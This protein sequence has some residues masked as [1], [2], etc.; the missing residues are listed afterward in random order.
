MTRRRSVRACGWLGF[1]WAALQFAAADAAWA[2]EFWLSGGERGVVLTAYHEMLEDRGGSFSPEEAAKTPALPPFVKIDQPQLNLGFSA[3]TFWL[4]TVLVNPTAKEI[5]SWLEISPTR[6]QTVSLHLL[7]QGR[8]ERLDAGTRQPF[9]LRAIKYRQSVFPVSVRPGEK[10]T[11]Y[12]RIAGETSISIETRIWS[13]AAFR[14]A[15]AQNALWNGVQMGILIAVLL[16]GL[17]LFHSF[18]IPAFLYL[19]LSMLAY[20]FNEIGMKG[21]S[22]ML[23][24]PN[25]TTWAT[26]SLLLFAL[27]AIVFHVLFVR[28]FLQ[29]RLILPHWDRVLGVMIFV[30]AVDVGWSQFVDYRSG[31]RIG[32]LLAPLALVACVAISALAFRRGVTAARFYIAA[33]SLMVGGAMIRS[34]ELHGLNLPVLLAEY[35]LPLS[36]IFA[37]AILMATMIDGVLQSQRQDAA[38][39]NERLTA[40]EQ[41]RRQLEHAVQLRTQEL[42]AALQ[43][44]GAANDAKTTLLAR[45]S[46]D[47]RAPLATIVGQARLLQRHVGADDTRYPVA[48][49]NSARHQLALIDELLE[50]AHS[51]QEGMA[52]VSRPGYLQVFLQEIAHEA[53][54][55][56]SQQNN[57]F[58]FQSA[59]HLPAVIVADLKRLRQVLLNLL[60]NA[61]KFTTDGKIVLSVRRD[62]AMPQQSGQV[63]L[64]FEVSDT[65]PG[66]AE[67]SRE[68]IFEPF[69]RGPEAAGKPGVGLG[70]SI[71]RL[72]VNTAGGQLQVISARG[73]GSQF[74][75]SV[76]FEL[77]AESEVLREPELISET[78]E[79]QANPDDS[80]GGPPAEGLIC[81]EVRVVQLRR[82]IEHGLVTEIEEWIESMLRDMPESA[83]FVRQLD[84]ALK[85]LD[86][87]LL[88]RLVAKP[89]APN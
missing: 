89:G 73:C 57:R 45:I 34:L 58:V 53:E 86:F 61:A 71:A 80:S 64:R 42:H 52:L 66:I 1:L 49:E 82:F 32:S 84:E 35:G 40:K 50:F 19:S 36:V 21:Y 74:H 20:F 3:S 63:W 41:Q 11:A 12:I 26:S 65:G 13:E 76:P 24:W 56:A 69:Q 5:T 27:L 87:N 62:N 60:S 10:V 8:W 59:E 72:I 14:A 39:Q 43:Q 48:I 23:L 54:F 2:E 70:L 16:C 31:A 7:K 6:L 81:P 22:F 85:R 88:A 18:R 38:S 47:L 33:T 75:F 17:I 79:G 37:T 15:E 83:H 55:L 29:T 30:I 4:K 67:E 78:G 68:R 44:A 25:A 46:H 9:N 77:A 28:E 51:G